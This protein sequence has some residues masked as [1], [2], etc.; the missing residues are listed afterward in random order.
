VAREPPP[1]RRGRH[2]VEL[3]RGD[4]LGDLRHRV[5]GDVAGAGVDCQDRHRQPTAVDQLG[6][7]VALA[8]HGAEE[9]DR[10]AQA[11]RTGVHPGE[12]VDVPLDDGARRAA[13]RREGVAGQERAFTPDEQHLGDAR[14]AEEP[15]V[16]CPT[17]GDIGQQ[18]HPE[19]GES[20][21][22]RGEAADQFG[23]LGGQADRADPADVLTGE[24]HGPQVEALDQTVQAASGG[25]ARVRTRLGAGIA[26]PREVDRDHVVVG[27]EQWD[28][29][30]E[31]PPGFGEAVHEQDRS[32][33]V[34]GG[35]VVQVPPSD[36]Q[37]G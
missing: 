24:V 1:G 2:A 6:D 25:P 36:R 17:V 9:P 37:P 13:H 22:D 10:A 31:G 16:P 35:D 30:V 21:L 4:V 27:G 33:G 32:A 20:G 34:A 23:M 8:E 15:D 19:A 12:L 3:H 14:G 18:L 26:E 7:L 11:A 28:E 5:A 29:L